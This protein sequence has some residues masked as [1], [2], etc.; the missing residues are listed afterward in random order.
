[1]FGQALQQNWRG[2]R[3]QIYF[4]VF[5][6]GHIPRAQNQIS[7]SLARTTKFFYRELY[8]IDSFIPV[9]LPITHQ[10]LSN[11]SLLSSKKKEKIRLVNGLNPS[12]LFHVKLGHNVIMSAG[13][14]R[15]ETLK[16]N[17]R[18]QKVCQASRFDFDTSIPFDLV[19]VCGYRQRHDVWSARNLDLICSSNQV[20]SKTYDLDY[21]IINMKFQA[22]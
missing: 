14:L 1:M 4:P 20:Y 3:L 12:N 2:Q 22:N 8:F 16:I 7:N 6:I 18:R 10:S 13:R 9:W 5:K 15:G 21:F 19:C 17:K 11:I